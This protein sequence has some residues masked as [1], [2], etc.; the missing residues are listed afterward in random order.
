VKTI[1]EKK[2]KRG[3]IVTEIS[4]FM[5]YNIRKYQ[6]DY[7]IFTNFETD[8][9]NWHPDM[10]DYFAS[11]WKVFENT[12]KTCIVHTSI[13]KRF[14]EYSINPTICHPELVSGSHKSARDAE[15]NLPAG[16]QG[17]A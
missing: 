2:Q 3:Y 1:L 5:A 7:A 9:L 16:R 6:S 8:H 4:S 13:T 14:K 11:K 10:K 15:I 12:K 17:S